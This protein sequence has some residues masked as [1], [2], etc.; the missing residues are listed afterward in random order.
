M[1][2][3]LPNRYVVQFLIRLCERAGLDKV[4]ASLAEVIR[5]GDVPSEFSYSVGQARLASCVYSALTDRANLTH[6]MRQAC[7]LALEYSTAQER[8]FRDEADL[9]QTDLIEVLISR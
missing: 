6:Y 4:A 7:A 1:I 2:H 3:E 9:I 5:T 8:D